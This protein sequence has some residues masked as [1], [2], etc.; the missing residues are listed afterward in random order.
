MAKPMSV[1]HRCYN[2]H[3]TVRSQEEGEARKKVIKLP[4][5]TYP[6]Y[7]LFSLTT[8]HTNKATKYSTTSKTITK[9]T[10]KICSNSDNKITSDKAPA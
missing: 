7:P 3:A 8:L 10:N 9:S 1:D 2:K 5:K 6:R 4:A